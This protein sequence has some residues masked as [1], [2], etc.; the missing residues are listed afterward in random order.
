MTVSAAF[1][2]VRRND[3]VSAAQAAGIFGS[4]ITARDIELGADKTGRTVVFVDVKSI[5]SRGRARC[6]SK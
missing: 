6:S 2:L 5:C 1:E 3:L 4:R